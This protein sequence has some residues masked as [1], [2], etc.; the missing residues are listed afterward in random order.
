MSKFSFY[1]VILAVMAVVFTSPGVIA[2]SEKPAE[3]C[4]NDVAEDPSCPSRPHIIKC[5]AKYLD[6][7]KNNHLDRVELEEAIN[8]LAWYAKGILKV[9]GSVDKIMDKCDYDKDGKISID[10][11]MESTTETCLASCFKRRAFKG[12]FFPECDL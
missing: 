5:A 12:A 2:D 10:H 4:A 11:D 8:S 6:T 3:E 7:N 1:W 9:I